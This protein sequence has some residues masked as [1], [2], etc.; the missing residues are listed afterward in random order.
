MTTYL[1]SNLVDFPNSHQQCF[2][3][4]L[5]CLTTAF[6]M[7]ETILYH[8][9]RYSNVYVASLDQKAA[10]DTVRFRALFLKLGRLGFTGHFLRLLMSTFHNLKTV[11]C[12]SR[13]TS[14][15]IM[16][17]RSV[18]QGGVLSTFLYLVYVNDILNDIKRSGCGSKVM[19]V[20][21]GNPAIADNISLLA[22][23]PVHLQKM[24]NIVYDYC[25]H[26]NVSI[27]VDKSSVT[28]FT[29]GR[30]QPEV[31]IRY[32]NRSFIQ[33]GSF[34]HLGIVY[35]YNLKDKDRVSQRLQKKQR[36]L[37]FQC[38]RKVSMPRELTRKS[39]LIFFPR[40]S[41]LLH[42]DIALNTGVK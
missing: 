3:P 20:C 37:Y 24:V 28:V 9:E 30:S 11:V 33:T 25:Q 39:Q 8:M 36:M 38:Q 10:F 27:N 5:S 2:Q 32:G 14:D 15:T 29:K 41:F 34:V 16:V 7:Q 19:S 4:G 12:G 23:T 1:K 35:S 40:L 26:C 42:C 22:L 13:S 31:N 21:C 6:A 18:R 17:K